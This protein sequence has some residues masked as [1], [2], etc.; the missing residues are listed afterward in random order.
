LPH[1]GTRALLVR[2]FL[3]VDFVTLKIKSFLP[4][5]AAVFLLAACAQKA[6]DEKTVR[7]GLEKYIAERRAD[8]CLLIERFPWDAPASP[9]SA[10]VTPDA[11]RTSPPFIDQQ[12][13]A[14]LEKVGLVR[15]SRSASGDSLRRFELTDEGH[16]YYQEYELTDLVSYQSSIGGWLCYAKVVMT[17]D[18]SWEYYRPDLVLA[19]YQTELQNVATWATNPDMLAAFPELER[20]MVFGPSPLQRMSFVP[21]PDGWVVQMNI[22]DQR[23]RVRRVK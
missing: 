17:G 8:K 4:F 16:K 3:N 18:V 1:S 13:I 23:T 20:E 6:I 5:L 15:Q 21:G 2:T 11:T 12:Q 7:K 9:E 14:V 10:G 19:T 22:G